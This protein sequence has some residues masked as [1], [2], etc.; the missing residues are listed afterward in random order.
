MKV[1]P[2]P[3]TDLSRFQKPAHELEILPGP[4]REVKSATASAH[5]LWKIEDGEWTL[6]H[7]PWDDR[8]T[9]V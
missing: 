4:P 9:P 7:N 6:R 2:S 5:H 3:E 1:H 8:I